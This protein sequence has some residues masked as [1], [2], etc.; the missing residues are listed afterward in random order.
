MIVKLTDGTWI[1]ASEGSQINHYLPVPI[2]ANDRIWNGEEYVIVTHV[3]GYE[4]ESVVLEEGPVSYLIDLAWWNET[5]PWR[6][7]YAQTP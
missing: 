6:K 3:I 2:Y 1:E 5:K 7:N 4:T